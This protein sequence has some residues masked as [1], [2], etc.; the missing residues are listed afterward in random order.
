MRPAENRGRIETL[1]AEVETEPG[2]KIPRAR[3]EGTPMR[4]HALGISHTALPGKQK[5]GGLWV[6]SFT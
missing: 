6:E 1:T 2:V 3:L 4:P 5:N